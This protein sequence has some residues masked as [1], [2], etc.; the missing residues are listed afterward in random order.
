MD[1]SELVPRQKK[2]NKQ[3]IETKLYYGCRETLLRDWLLGSSHDPILLLTGLSIKLLNTE[4]LDRSK[5]YI[6]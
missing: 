5:F 6:R 4:Q 1:Q 2:K 3:N